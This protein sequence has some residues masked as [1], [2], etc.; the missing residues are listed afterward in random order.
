MQNIS[1]F[2]RFKTKGNRKQQRIEEK[3]VFEKSK[4]NVNKRL[5]VSCCAKDYF[6]VYRLHPPNSTYGPSYCDRNTKLQKT[7][8]DSS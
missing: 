2:I 1:P 7:A 6:D 5:N 3:Y 8:K 4:Q